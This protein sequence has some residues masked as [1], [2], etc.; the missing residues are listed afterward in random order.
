ME[1]A[2]TKMHRR[3]VIDNTSRFTSSAVE[4]FVYLVNSTFVV[5][6]HT[7]TNMRYTFPVGP[8]RQ[9]SG[10]N[11]VTLGLCE[12]LHTTWSGLFLPWAAFGPCRE[13]ERFFPSTLVSKRSPFV[14]VPRAYRSL[15]TSS[16][17]NRGGCRLALLGFLSG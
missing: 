1:T 11:N 4:I 15:M 8:R 13:Y 14:L 7:N 6:C 12:A 2:M 9:F 5:T 17:D 10:C 16:S 3:R